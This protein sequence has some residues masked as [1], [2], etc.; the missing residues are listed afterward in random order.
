MSFIDCGSELF[1]VWF[2]FLSVV[3]IL[4]YGHVLLL[5]LLHDFL[6]RLLHL[7]GSLLDALDFPFSLQGSM[8]YREITVGNPFDDHVFR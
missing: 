1:D 5:H 2:C 3:E 8:V 7:L 4:W 6:V